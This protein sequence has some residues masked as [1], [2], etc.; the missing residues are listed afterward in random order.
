MKEAGIQGK[1]VKVVASSEDKNFS[2]IPKEISFSPDAAYAH[3]TSNNTI[4]GTQ[5]AS[6]PDTG[7]VPLICDMSSDIMSKP[8]DPVSYTHLRAH[9]T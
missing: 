6:F 8:F 5:W 9:E 7:G 1:E 2:Y 4:K 3:I